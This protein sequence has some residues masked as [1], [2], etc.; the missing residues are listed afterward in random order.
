TLQSAWSNNRPTPSLLVE[1][2]PDKM[3]A[4]KVYVT[5][6]VSSLKSRRSSFTIR[7]IALRGAETTQANV[8]F[9]APPELFK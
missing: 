9:E 3:R 5:A 2:N 8:T 6:P 7:A 4:V 1:V